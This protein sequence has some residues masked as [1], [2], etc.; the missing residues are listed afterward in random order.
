VTRARNITIQLLI[1]LVLAL[2]LWTF[3]NLS[4][5]PNDE[6]VYNDIPINVRGLDPELL[7]VDENGLPRL[8]QSDLDTV[9]IEIETDLVTLAELRASDISAFVELRGL[10]SGT[11]EVP[12]VLDFGQRTVDV[13]EQDP[14]DVQIR[15]EEV[16][17]N[18]VPITTELLGNL[19]ASFE[20][21]EP[22]IT[23][24]DETITQTQVVGPRSRVERV[25]QVTAGPIDLRQTQ[26]TL[27][28]TLPLVPLAANG[29]P[30]NGVTTIPAEVQVLIEVRPLIGIKRV[31]VLG[32]VVGSPAPGYV[33]R[34]I[35][36]DPPLID[37]FGNSVGLAAVNFIETEPIDIG[38]TTRPITQEVDLRFPFGVQPQTDS[39]RQATV[40]IDVV[41]VDQQ[42]DVQLALVV[43]AVNEPA[44]LE[45]FLNPPAVQ[46][47]LRGSALALAQLREDPLVAIVDLAGLGA[48]LH[49]LTPEVDLPDNVEIV[50]A[51][52]E[53]VVGLNPSVTQ[54]PRPSPSPIVN[55]PTSSSAT[56]SPPAAPPAGP[57][58]EQP[59]SASSPEPTAPADSP[60]PAAPPTPTTGAESTSNPPLASPTRAPLPLTDLPPTPTAT[61]ILP[62]LPGN[63]RSPLPLPSPT[64]TTP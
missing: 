47:T 32:N 35:E 44:D 64:P 29:D 23:V 28:L 55:P 5:N 9:D 46:V 43:E 34:S 40:T 63:T 38:G 57:S 36:S 24:D 59:T 58:P 22:E 53:V 19:P 25:E 15:L 1:S 7:L 61:S 48:G 52:P 13:L 50:G 6:Q 62:D 3:V 37:V 27:E 26:S 42:I 2:V 39:P 4:T 16:I 41:P 8:S 30:V 56:P 21:G 11:H 17:T 33:V 10:E 31:P 51:V 60:A 49:N 54:S 14:Q 18:T 12:V 45:V 20:G